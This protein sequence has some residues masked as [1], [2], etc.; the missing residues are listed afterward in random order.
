MRRADSNTNWVFITLLI[1]TPTSQWLILFPD[2]GYS[3]KWLQNR[4][5]SNTEQQR[6][7]KTPSSQI[8]EHVCFLLKLKTNYAENMTGSLTPLKERETPL[9]T[10]ETRDNP[11]LT[12]ITGDDPSGATFAPVDLRHIT[13][14]MYFHSN[15]TYVRN[16]P[17]SHLAIIFCGEWCTW[18]NGSIT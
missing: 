17:I 13:H 12:D 11:G 7:I 9:T 2:K 18:L 10:S 8:R 14:K 6:T 15:M 16:M 1:N 5:A 4:F 3:Q